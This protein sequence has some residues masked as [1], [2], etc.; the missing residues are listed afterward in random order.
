[1]TGS[2]VELLVSQAPAL[3]LGGLVGYIGS[4][5]YGFVDRLYKD[6]DR[7]KAHKLNVARHVLDVCEEGSLRNFEVAPKDIKKVRR[8]ITDV[9]GFD[10]EMGKVLKDLVGGWLIYSFKITH[11]GREFED[12]EMRISTGRELEAN[13]K[14]LQEWANKIRNGGFFSW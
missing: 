4:I 1:M 2:F 3:A 8:T 9:E 5:W 6:H 14:K 11:T 10:K 13:R 7:K 12:L